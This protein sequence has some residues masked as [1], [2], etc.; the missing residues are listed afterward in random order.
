[1]KCKG[2]VRYVDHEGDLMLTYVSDAGCGDWAYLDSSPDSWIDWMGDTP[3]YFIS[4]DGGD[5]HKSTFLLPEE[6]LL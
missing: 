5:I 6:Y 4:D 2:L 1:M 3:D